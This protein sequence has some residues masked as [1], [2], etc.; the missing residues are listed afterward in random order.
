MFGS[1]LT[2]K[3]SGVSVSCIGFTESVVEAVA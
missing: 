1:L 2:L 3:D